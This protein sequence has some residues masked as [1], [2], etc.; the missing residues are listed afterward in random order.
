[1][2]NILIDFK[3]EILFRNNKDQYKKFF[4]AYRFGNGVYAKLDNFYIL[5]TPNRIKKVSRPGS[6]DL[7]LPDNWHKVA[8]IIPESKRKTR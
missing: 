8:K 7:V 6:K 4:N 5:I 3:F 2:Q 1:M